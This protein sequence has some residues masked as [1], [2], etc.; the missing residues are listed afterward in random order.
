MA[1]PEDSGITAT[2]PIPLFISFKVFQTYEWTGGNLGFVSGTDSR[3]HCQ[4]AGPIAVIPSLDLRVKPRQAFAALPY[5]TGD[6]K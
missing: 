2:P 1:K 5:T 4:R 3:E 6:T